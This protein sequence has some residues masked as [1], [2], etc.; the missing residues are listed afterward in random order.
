MFFGEK[1]A[2]QYFEEGKNSANSPRVSS[3]I[4]SICL[5][6]LHFIQD[7]HEQLQFVLAIY[8][9]F[10]LK[11]GD[12]RTFNVFHLHQEITL[13]LAWAGSTHLDGGFSAACKKPGTHDFADVLSLVIDGLAKQGLEKPSLCDLI[14][15][16][17]ILIHDAPEGKV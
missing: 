5:A 1:L 6:E 7:R 4:F 8:L 9:D 15:L 10:R 2:Q 12:T 17:E 14:H 11:C 3:A 16:S 13:N